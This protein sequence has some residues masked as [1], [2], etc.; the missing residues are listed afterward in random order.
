MKLKLVIEDNGFIVLSYNRYEKKFDKKVSL[1]TPSLVNRFGVQK[2]KNGQ[3]DLLKFAIEYQHYD[4]HKIDEHI[5]CED[6][7]CYNEHCNFYKK[8]MEIENYLKEKM[9]EIAIR[10]EVSLKFIHSIKWYGDFNPLMEMKP[11]YSNGKYQT[12]FYMK[13]YL[14]S[15]DVYFDNLKNKTTE[16]DIVLDFLFY[17]IDNEKKEMI[18][19]PIW[20]IHK[21]TLI[22]N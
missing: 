7:E 5:F 6:V 3:T 1:I 9:Q 8:V 2:K 16:N 4:K 11:K 22:M 18:A 12:E 19:G 17:K 13:Q 20:A 15:H 21:S 14:I 10:N